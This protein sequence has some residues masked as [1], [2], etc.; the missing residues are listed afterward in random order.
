MIAKDEEGNRA[1]IV[2]ATISRDYLEHIAERREILSNFGPYL[3]GSFHVRSSG[4]LDC[5]KVEKR[6]CV[7]NSLVDLLRMK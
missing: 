1:L 7:Y 2:D 5:S 4:W 3:P 6:M